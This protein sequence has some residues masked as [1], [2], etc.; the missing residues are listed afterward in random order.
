MFKECIFKFDHK[1][2]NPP[3]KHHMFIWSFIKEKYCFLASS[4]LKLIQMCILLSLCHSHVLISLHYREKQLLEDSTYNYQEPQN[5]FVGCLYLEIM[6][7]PRR[8]VYFSAIM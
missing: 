2:L 3:L 8:S 4:Q 1:I 7:Q 5:G 6:G